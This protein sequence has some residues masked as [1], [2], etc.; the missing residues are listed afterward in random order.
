MK[1][2]N[3]GNEAVEYLCDNCLNETVLNNIFNQLMISKIE[4]CNNKYITDYINK[5]EDFRELRNCVPV[6][7][8]K[9]DSRVSE[10]FYCRYYRITNNPLFEESACKYLDSHLIFDVKKQN[11]LYDLLR[12]YLRQDYEKPIKW[13]KI[14]AS[15]NNL[16]IE[17]YD[18][19]SE[20]C[21]MV[22][23]YDTAKKLLQ[24]GKS[25]L[26]S[27]DSYL[28]SNKENMEKSLD[29]TKNLLDRY[30][31]GKPY[32]PNTEERRLKIKKIYDEKGI[33]YHDYSVSKRQYQ[34]RSDR[35]VKASNFIANNEWF[36]DIPN[37][38][39]SFFCRGIFSTKTVITMYDIGAV[40]ISNNR[41]IDTFYSIVKPWEDLKVKQEA[42]NSLKISMKELNNANE[43]DIVM[44]KF[45][46]FIGDSLVVSTEGL[47]LQKEILTRAMRYAF[48]K[49]LD[50]PI[51]D[52]LD[53][54]ASKSSIFD[55][56]NNTRDYLLN[57]YNI[58]DGENSLDKAIANYK[59]IEELRKIQK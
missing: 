53:Y 55:F 58:L 51:G 32:W 29:N 9:L 13:C 42:A 11:I 43:V 24:L 25:K 31:N 34:N 2:F 18:I 19:A 15:N 36:D 48:Y 12:F 20:H 47:S 22:G 37:N 35:R 26:E 44:K 54:A 28:F 14:I 39:I 59:I 5:L 57:Y 41:I 49:K 8:S 3:C 30:T 7:L 6:I 27:K 23:E 52:I 10:Y 16:C 38:Y 46:D 50:N 4:D 40:K 21:S 17:L 33:N 1:C 56:E 45:M